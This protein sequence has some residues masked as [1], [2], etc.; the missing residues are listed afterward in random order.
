MTTLVRRR[1]IVVDDSA[2]AERIGAQLKVSR[3]QAGL[4][5]QQLAEGRYTKAYVSALEKGLAK[6]SMAALNFF[7]D[8]LGRTASSFLT[9]EESG[10][11]RLEAD[12]LLATGAW[13]QAADAYESLL[14]GAGAGLVRAELLRGQAEALVRLDRGGEA[15][16]PA[17]EAADIF[18]RL[19]RSRDW[20]LAA[21]W[22]AGGMFKTD[23]LAEARSVLDGVLTRVRGGLEVEPDFVVRVLAAFAAIATRESD[24]RAALGYLEE[25]RAIGSDLDDRRRGACL[26][27]LA[28]TYR[29]LGDLEA[30]I[31]SGTQ[32]LALMR[33]ADADV[34]AG[35]LENDLALAFLAIGNTARAD[36]LAT[37]SDERLRGL[38]DDRMRAHAV[39]T[40]A[41]IA[42]AVD[43]PERALEL[44]DQAEELAEATGNTKAMTSVQLTRAKALS[45]LARLEESTDAYEAAAALVREHGPKAR[46]QEVLGEWADVLARMGQHEQAYALSREALRA[47]S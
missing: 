43:A 11:T 37:A 4:T 38:G 27:S 7:A 32:G 35:M 39:E 47:R 3:K 29:E 30:A 33:A 5:Q 2:L 18:G 24:H 40:R 14:P 34:E 12:L 45:A 21:Y 1:R 13:L 22:L 15:I 9:Q 23:N 20:A 42:L 36:A 44:L 19:H 28:T 26:V 25:A 16:A 6:P 46:L 41:Q 31:R 10:W 17:T 8:R